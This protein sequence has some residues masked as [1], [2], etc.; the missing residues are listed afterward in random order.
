M[1]ALV[2]LP[3]VAYI[4][5]PPQAAALVKRLADSVHGH[6]REIAI[7]VAT[8]VGVWLI[9]KGTIQLV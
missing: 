4:V 9:A 3:I 7:V 6:A 2:E 8:V 5:D 1:F